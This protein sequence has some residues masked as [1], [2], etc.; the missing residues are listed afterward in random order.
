MQAWHIE[1]EMYKSYISYGLSNIKNVSWRHFFLQVSRIVS[2]IML[3]FAPFCK[4]EETW[5]MMLGSPEFPFSWNCIC[6]YTLKKPKLT[7][8]IAYIQTLGRNNFLRSSICASPVAS[9]C[10]SESNKLHGGF[11]WYSKARCAELV[12]EATKHK[13]PF[14]STLAFFPSLGRK[15]IGSKSLTWNRFFVQVFASKAR[16]FPVK[17]KLD[18]TVLSAAITFSNYR[19]GCDQF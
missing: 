19:W 2:K 10:H 15:K 7:S 12:F 5:E 13:I 8:G 6:K 17:H 9:T 3:F 4:H 11:P 1:C 14:G 16:F 18:P